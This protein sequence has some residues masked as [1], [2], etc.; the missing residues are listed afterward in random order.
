MTPAPVRPAWG[1]R[2]KARGPPASGANLTWAMGLA[3]VESDCQ[4]EGLA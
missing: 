3:T 4:V 1:A 2:R